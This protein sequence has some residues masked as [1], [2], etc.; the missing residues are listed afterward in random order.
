M[1]AVVTK[2][3]PHAIYVNVVEDIITGKLVNDR[4]VEVGDTINVMITYL[5]KSKIALDFA[6]ENL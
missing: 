4:T 2:V 1:P 3:M 5:G 6:E